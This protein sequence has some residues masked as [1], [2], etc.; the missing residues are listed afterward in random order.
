MVQ[1]LKISFVQ[2]RDDLV[3]HPR[4]E[5]VD[6][7]LLNQGSGW[8][9]R[10]GNEDDFSFRRDRVYH[11]LQIRLKICRRRFNGVGI[12]KL[13]DEFVSDKGL[14][15]DNHLVV[16]IKKRVADELDDL[17]GAVSENNIFAA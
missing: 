4:Q 13:R 17:V 3:R 8:V 10:I 2:D 5:V 6:L 14:L 1:K 15:R 11:C 12:K 7:L 9:V 16:A